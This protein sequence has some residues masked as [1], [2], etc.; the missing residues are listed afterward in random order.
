MQLHTTVREIRQL[1]P[2]RKNLSLIIRHLLL[3]MVGTF[4]GFP[5]IIVLICIQL[6]NRNDRCPFLYKRKLT[7]L[8][9]ICKGALFLYMFVVSLMLKEREIIH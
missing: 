3:K 1:C 9:R 4:I 6:M 7:T 2:S 8:V 5:F